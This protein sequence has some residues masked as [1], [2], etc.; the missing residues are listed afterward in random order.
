MLQEDVLL[1][2]KQLEANL[3]SAKDTY[4][5]ELKAL[6]ATCKHEPTTDVRIKSEFD[7]PKIVTKMQKCKYCDK[8]LGTS[9]RLD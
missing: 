5:K 7:T 9:V 1:K 2:R 3:L 4:A 6:Q 8:I